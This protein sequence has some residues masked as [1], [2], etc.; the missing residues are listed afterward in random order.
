MSCQ[1][2]EYEDKRLKK[3]AFKDRLLKLELDKLNNQKEYVSNALRQERYQLER[4]FA[5]EQQNIKHQK[6]LS[7]DELQLPLSPVDLKKLSPQFVRRYSC[8]PRLGESTGVTLPQINTTSKQTS[9]SE[10]IKAQFRQRS[11][12]LLTLGT[13]TIAVQEYTEGGRAKRRGRPEISPRLLRRRGS[14]QNTAQ[15]N[16]DFSERVRE[17]LEKL[18]NDTEPTKEITGEKAAK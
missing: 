2:S 9:S 10:P 6:C 5:Q 11:E 17:F 16:N 1:R 13:P 14:A 8:T 15:D 7:S 12:S 4:Q 3:N 18:K